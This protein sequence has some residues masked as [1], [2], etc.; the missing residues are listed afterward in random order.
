MGREGG[1][2]K[3]FLQNVISGFVS[4]SAL[5]ERLARGGGELGRPP[6]LMCH[7][8]CLLDKYWQ[9]LE[10]LPVNTDHQHEKIV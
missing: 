9:L 3:Y 2:S 8:V 1:S 7:L 6:R 5:N 4:K 10:M